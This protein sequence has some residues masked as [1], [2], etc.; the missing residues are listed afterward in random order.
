MEGRATPEGTAAYARA[1]PAAAGHYRE[2][3]GL[4]LASVGFGSYLGEE[5]DAADAAYAEAFAVGLASGVNVLDTAANYRGR[6]SERAVG[7]ALRAAGV[8]REQVLVATKAGFLPVDAAAGAPSRQLARA[9]FDTGVLRPEDVVAGCHAMTPRYLAHEMDASLGRLGLGAVDVF[10]LH[11][12]E[13]HLETGVPRDVFEQRLRE[14]FA[15][16]ESARRDGRIGVYGL[17]TWGGLRRAPGHPHHVGLE[18]ALDLAREVG[19]PQHGL[20]AIELP[21]N[22]AMPEAGR[23]ATQPWEGRPVP[24]LQAARAA[25]LLVLGSASLMQGQLLRRLGASLIERLGARDPL[26]AALQFARSTP[27]L[28]TALVGTGRAEH[29]RQNAAVAALPTRPDVATALLGT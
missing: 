2:A 28:T 19:G 6:R 8:P 1:H 27:G 21:Y 14:A 13:T 26:A 11:N 22:L 3:L 5:S 7:E 12:P 24:A 16:L 15:T 29:A 10:F 17:A 23:A 9:Y 4:T 20:R 18:R 25:G